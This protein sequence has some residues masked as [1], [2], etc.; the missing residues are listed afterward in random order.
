MAPNEN[1]P[2]APDPEALEELVRRTRAGSQEAATALYARY[3]CYVLELIG[4][5]Y[6]SGG[7]RLRKLFDA[8]D[9]A[10]EVWMT[11]F[12]KIR[13]GATFASERA[14]V[15]FLRAVTK[16]CFR[17]LYRNHIV[18]AK[19]SLYREVRLNPAAHDRPVTGAA[20]PAKIAADKDE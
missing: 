12:R 4:R 9:L 18:R 17:K 2:P 5:S 3:H 15:A 16:N 14:F 20:D 19:R 6:L 8:D 11:V 7:H 1:T 10:Q 13:E